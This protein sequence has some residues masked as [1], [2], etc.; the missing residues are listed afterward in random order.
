MGRLPRK[1]KSAARPI[2]DSYSSEESQS[3]ESEQ[4]TKPRD[5]SKFM[6]RQV[7]KALE[8]DQD[9]SSASDF[10]ETGKKRK[11]A[12]TAQRAMSK[13]KFK[14]D[15]RRKREASPEVP[16]MSEDDYEEERPDE[17]PLFER[18]KK[19]LR[20][21]T[22]AASIRTTNLPNNITIEVLNSPCTLHLNLRDLLSLQTGQEALDQ[23]LDGPTLLESQTPQERT[24]TPET[25]ADM[26]ADARYACFLELE[27]DLR[28]R[29]YR[30]LLVKD[31]VVKFNPA[32]NLSRTAAIL[33]TNK[34]VH[35]ETSG[36]LYGENAF[37]LDR[38]EKPRGS[39]YTPWKEVGYKDMRRF[40]EMIGPHN[41]AKM[42]FLSISLSDAIP[43]Y[44][45]ELDTIER[46]YFNDPVVYQ[47]FKLI[48]QSDAVF[49]KLVV[50]FGG[51]GALEWDNGAFVRAFTN[52][53]CHQLIKTCRWHHSRVNSALYGRMKAFME[54][55]M[56]P[57]VDP[58]KQRAPTMQH[59]LSLGSSGC[60]YR[61][62][63]NTF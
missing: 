9:V 25:F 61:C 12:G 54:V 60:P 52:I 13:K 28:N 59:E 4:D 11:R 16:S 34:Q 15:A 45:P 31:E 53:K 30:S 46:R 17:L 62:A 40:L 47:M 51:R 63:N 38:T 48:G 7:D 19:P 27:P 3:S 29:I 2:V 44:S 23:D 18:P 39:L 10:E 21:R 6:D 49:E 37:H 43:V 50:D 35:R 56:A 20:P 1:A 5:F 41:L 36:I 32:P 8:E 14:L 55:P 22:P 58:D 24:K 42:R 26:R 57:N 33:R